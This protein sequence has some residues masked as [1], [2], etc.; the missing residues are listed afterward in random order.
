M[1]PPPVPSPFPG[2]AFSSPWRTG[3]VPI[4][5]IRV[6]HLQYPLLP[7]KQPCSTKIFGFSSSTQTTSLTLETP[8]NP[9]YSSPNS[10]SGQATSSVIS[11][12]PLHLVSHLPLIGRLPP[13]SHLPLVSPSTQAP[14]ASLHPII[15]LSTTPLRSQAPHHSSPI[16]P[17]STHTFI[18]WSASRVPTIPRRSLLRLTFS[19][20]INEN[21]L[22]NN[23]PPPLPQEDQDTSTNGCGCRGRGRRTATRGESNTIMQWLWM[24]FSSYIMNASTNHQKKSTTPS[25]QTKN[26]TIT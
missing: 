20:Y 21:N 11:P 9:S 18:I 22:I 6:H 14:P 19:E 2:S 15:A 3:H 23:P 16:T 24:L 1:P 13:I 12:S 7:L 17:S 25:Q 4:I 10:H 26:T 8:S 5:H